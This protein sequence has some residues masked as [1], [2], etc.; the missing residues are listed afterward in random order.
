VQVAEELRRQ[1]VAVLGQN[2]LVRRAVVALGAR[3]QQ[4]VAGSARPSVSHH[5]QQ[6]ACGGDRE[7]GRRRTQQPLHTPGG[8]CPVTTTR[9][10]ATRACVSTLCTR[11]SASPSARGC[12]SRLI[13][14]TP[15]SFGGPPGRDSQREILYWA[16]KG[17]THEL[18][19]STSLVPT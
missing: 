5:P 13:A 9:S 6:C 17:S 14:H 19:G 2:Q 3:A 12:V 10:R 18:Y 8:M 11:A 1:H 7:A 15:H 4:R 16:G